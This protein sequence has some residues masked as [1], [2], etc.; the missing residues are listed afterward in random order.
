MVK[1]CQDLLQFQNRIEA[2][3][4]EHKRHARNADDWLSDLERSI[5]HIEQMNLPPEEKLRMIDELNKQVRKVDS[6]R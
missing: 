4:D 5:Q 6:L 3:A 2:L 1:Q